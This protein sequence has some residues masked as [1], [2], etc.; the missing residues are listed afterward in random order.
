MIKSQLSTY[1][2]VLGLFGFIA[3]LVDLGLVFILLL[4]LVGK[5]LPSLS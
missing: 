5:L 2:L 3:L 1:S 4:V